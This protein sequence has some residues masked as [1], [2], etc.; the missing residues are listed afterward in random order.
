MGYWMVQAIY[1]NDYLLISG[2]L[3]FS[4]LIILSGILIADVMYTVIDPRIIYT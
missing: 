1:V 4:S 3:V 2:L